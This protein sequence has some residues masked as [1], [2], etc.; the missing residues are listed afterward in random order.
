MIYKNLLISFLNLSGLKTQKI[1]LF[2]VI[3]ED[4]ND[5]KKDGDTI[6]SISEAVFNKLLTALPGLIASAIS[7]SNSGKNKQKINQ[8]P[9]KKDIPKPKGKGKPKTINS[10]GETLTKNGNDK[11]ESK[12]PKHLN[13]VFKP[14]LKL[15]SPI[16]EN[17][18][19]EQSPR[20]MLPLNIY[21]Y[22]GGDY[23]NFEQMLE[24]HKN[25]IEKLIRT[26]G[27]AEASKCYKEQRNYIFCLIEGRDAKHPAFTA[28][29]DLNGLR[30]LDSWCHLYDLAVR[31][32]DGNKQAYACLNTFLYATRVLEENFVRDFSSITNPP[33]GP[34]SQIL[35]D[36]FRTYVRNEF[37]TRGIVDFAAKQAE[38]TIVELNFNNNS[39][40]PNGVKR[41][42]SVLNELVYVVNNIEM[43]KQITELLSRFKNSNFLIEYLKSFVNININDFNYKG[44]SKNTIVRKVIQVTSPDLKMRDVAISD[45]WT[46]LTLSFYERILYSI[47]EKF[48]PNEI[49]LKNHSQGFKNAINANIK[50]KDKYPMGI[51]SYDISDW[52]DRLSRDLQSIVIE[53]LFDKETAYNWI[54][55]AMTCEW[56]HPQ[57]N[58]NIRYGA[59]QGMGTR[60]SMAIGTYTYAL[61][62]QYV[63]K[64][65]YKEYEPDWFG[66]VGDD[67]YCLDPLGFI[68]IYFES[69]D[70]PLN[71][72][73]KKGTEKGR[74]IEFVSRVAWDEID[75]SRISPRIINRAI[76]WEFIPTLLCVAEE[77]GID[78]PRSVLSS[79]LDVTTK[80]GIPY[81]NLLSNIL[82]VLICEKFALTQ[83]INSLNKDDENYNSLKSL[84]QNNVIGVSKEYLVRNNYLLDDIFEKGGFKVSFI[85]NEYFILISK[86]LNNYFNVTDK[87]E[88]SVINKEIPYTIKRHTALSKCC[89]FDI[90]SDVY[91]DTIEFIKSK[92]PSLVFTNENINVSV[93]HP[94][95]LINLEML[96]K[97][98]KFRT[99]M[100]NE[101]VR[102]GKPLIDA[103]FNITIQSKYIEFLGINTLQTYE[104][105]SDN[106]YYAL[107]ME[108]TR[109]FGRINFKDQSYTLLK[110]YDQYAESAMFII[111]DVVTK[112][113]GF[114]NLIYSNGTKFCAT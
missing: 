38:S 59:G 110:E 101:S 14:K 15:L 61:F 70:L 54:N 71:N 47:F 56:Y 113:P 107:T 28:S 95:V 16:L 22:K 33:K 111:D 52:S 25:L 29:T 67:L 104:Y 97:A 78:I 105:A 43:F 6:N 51:N 64:K 86:Y 93:L 57:S 112:L 35:L 17:I 94:S 50:Y 45:Y 24:I 106:K 88:N 99:K 74:F 32:S 80:E 79:V 76:K 100:F 69:I 89:V 37:N 19:G 46:Q 2:S 21:K 83:A 40:G 34:I 65:E 75:V 3:G 87:L 98:Q 49:G 63:L 42:D 91:K 31:A 18:L 8:R 55:L 27:F 10:L 73:G 92:K 81:G 20:F 109:L 11:K 85:K 12:T 72:K 7:N 60:A 96:K 26:R 5:D 77:R 90:N 58:T 84:I 44:K 36:E 9:P 68:P 23:I 62:I 102:T 13:Y 82:N 48:Y 1:S 108:T 53:E 41:L 66:V 4:T 103:I 114:P 39:N 30:F